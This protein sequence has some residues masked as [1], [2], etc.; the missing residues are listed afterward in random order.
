[1]YDAALYFGDKAARTSAL[2]GSLGLAPGEYVLATVHRA[3]NTDDPAR[4]RA[5]FGGL[6]LLAKEMPVVMPLHP[7]TRGALAKAGLEIRHIRVI[8][9]V[10]YLDMAALERGARLVT[11]DSGGI[12]K[13]A[14]FYRVPCLTLRT[15]TEWTD[16]VDLGWNTLLLPETPEEVP[17]AAARVLAAH[18]A[19]PAVSPYGDG[20]ACE[21]IVD[22]LLAG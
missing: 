12:Q 8:D 10:G 7:R 15:E 20:H 1:M 14:F 3:E 22:A 13:E 16:L 17:A 5:I 11:T 2:P 9:P 21:H 18:P 19:E 4:L 6:E